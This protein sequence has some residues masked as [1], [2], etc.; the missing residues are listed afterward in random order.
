M[1]LKGQDGRKAEIGGTGNRTGNVERER[2][3]QDN[4]N[5][6]DI[7]RMYIFLTAAAIMDKWYHKKI[8]NKE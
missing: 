7:D 1:T 3:E 6:T 5:R 8:N 4:Q 2:Q